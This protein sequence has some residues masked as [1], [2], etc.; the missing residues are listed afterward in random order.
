MIAFAIAAGLQACGVAPPVK[1]PAPA[2]PPSQEAPREA[3]P[4]ASPV[5]ALIDKAQTAQRAGHL[6]DAAASLERA[7][8]IDPYDPV[9]WQMLAQVR[10]AQGDGSQA[11]AM[12]AKSNSLAYGDDALQR[13]NWRI[14]AQARRMRGDVQGAREAEQ[15]AGD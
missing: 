13:E 9:A 7:V 8:R 12:A 6:E 1:S 4:S 15:R 3:P 2:P 11:E 5:V 14:I 10:L